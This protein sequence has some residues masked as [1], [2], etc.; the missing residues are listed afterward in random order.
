MSTIAN[1]LQGWANY[2]E[3]S[4]YTK[5]MMESRLAIC[6]QCPHKA[7]MGI[8]G[9]TVVQL[10]DVEANVFKCTKCNC[11]LASA[12][13]APGKRCPLNKWLE[14]GLENEFY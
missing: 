10:V 7:E 14:A 8:V 13:A 12:T 4:K 5:R 6:M 11:P 9:R 1:I 2:M 3:G